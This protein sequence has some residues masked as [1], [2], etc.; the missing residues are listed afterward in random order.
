MISPY[1]L[2]VSKVCYIFL[3]MKMV[4]KCNWLKLQQY[5]GCLFVSFLF[6][7]NVYISLFMALSDASKICVKSFT[8]VKFMPHSFPLLSHLKK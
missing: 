1:L 4:T 6:T 2:I 7:S 5:L 8:P 3:F